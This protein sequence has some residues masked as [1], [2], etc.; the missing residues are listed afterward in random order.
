MALPNDYFT[1]IRRLERSLKD[2]SVGLSER[3]RNER[4]L[5]KD[6]EK[7]AEENRVGL[8]EA[9]IEVIKEKPFLAR[10]PQIVYDPEDFLVEA[11]ESIA[12]TRGV[13]LVEA[14]VVAEEENPLIANLMELM[15]YQPERFE[16]ACYE[17]GK[18]LGIVGDSNGI[19]A[20]ILEVV[21]REEWTRQHAE[22]KEFAEYMAEQN[23]PVGVVRAEFSEGFEYFHGLKHLVRFPDSFGQTLERLTEEFSSPADLAN[24]EQIQR[25]CEYVVREV[26]N[27]FK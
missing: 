18:K 7:F 17:V 2:Y 13:D 16:A 21:Q 1:P 27:A 12:K 3:D 15:K 14:S 22:R 6:A 10:E 9:F 20:A 5:Q 26:S 25:D 8:D 11:S 4:W 19:V 24:Q 23:N